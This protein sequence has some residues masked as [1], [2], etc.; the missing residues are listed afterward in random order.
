MLD[1]YVVHLRNTNARYLA[2]SSLSNMYLMV[3]FVR[4][5]RT[6]VVLYTI[7]GCLVGACIHSVIQDT[8]GKYVW[9]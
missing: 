6:G 5:Q 7:T 8:S 2:L 4:S 9:F 3:W 1:Y